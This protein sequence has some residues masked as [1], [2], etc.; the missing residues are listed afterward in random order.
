M[1]FVSP[2]FL[3][4]AIMMLSLAFGGCAI[5]N[6]TKKT[7]DIK[8]KIDPEV[9]EVHGDSIKIS[10]R[11]TIPPKT[12][13]R[14]ASFS[15]EPSIKYGEKE[16]ALK[17]HIVYGPAAGKEVKG[18][19]IIDPKDGGSFTY[20]D[21]VAYTPELKKSELVLHLAVK[22]NH[23]DELIDQCLDVK[24]YTLT[25]GTITTSLT[26]KNNDEV[27][28]S[29]E[30]FDASTVTKAQLADNRFEKEKNP[31]GNKTFK[32]FGSDKLTSTQ[33]DRSMIFY[34]TI[35][36]AV[37]GKADRKKFQEQ[38]KEQMNVYREFIKNK[39]YKIN[40]ILVRSY[41]SPDGESASNKNLAE[42]RGDATSKFVKSELKKIGF[43]EVNDNEF[44]SRNSV[45]EDWEGLAK[46]VSASDITNKAE[47]L[48]IINSGDNDEV[49]ESK[50]KSYAKGY[51]ELRDEI[52]PSLR[53]AVVTISAVV[54]L[55]PLAELNEALK[56]DPGSITS[57][58]KLFLAQNTED[59]NTKLQLYK[60]FADSNPNDWRGPNNVAAV[61]IKQ[62][63]YDDALVQLDKANAMSPNNG[64]IANNYGVVY[65][66]KKD[67]AKADEYYK[68]AA[69][70]NINVGFNLG[71]L[72]LVEGL[73]P[74]AIS[75][76]NDNKCHYNSGLA[77]AMNTSYDE[78]KKSLDC[79]QTDQMD[80]SVFYLKAIVGAR[81]GNTEEMT[82]NLKRAVDLDSSYKAIAKEDLEF[83]K[84]WEK[85][86]F[87]NVVNQ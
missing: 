2:R 27:I 7:K 85:A 82:T 8:Y 47:I 83:R 11:V 76:Y 60:E 53:R 23:G 16:L 62:G 74:E 5:K 49:K 14:K 43:A 57:T 17:S 64:I 20:V 61:L 29:N 25:Y 44:H 56:N 26:A 36:Q 86:E 15:F 9:L 87:K 58:E 80:A 42:R 32:Y 18:A 84:Y 31:S 41:A 10:M 63:N 68:L 75:Q 71:N 69:G 28:I 48:E 59:L 35:E 3:L 50:I 38:N 33:A 30:N 46:A 21:K 6:L 1:K 22:L 24:P 72:Y 39:N 40:G 45:G 13:H 73:Y 65:K 55:R 77:Y 12:M 81:T 37:F 51:D 79:I 66:A 52:L 67:Y 19:Q 54:P 4:S 78:S 70:Q 34:F